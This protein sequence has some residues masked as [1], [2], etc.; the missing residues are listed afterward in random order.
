MSQ[1]SF[2][3]K[4]LSRINCPC[5]FDQIYILQLTEFAETSLA[6]K[7]HVNRSNMKLNSPVV[8]HVL[9]ISMSCDSTVPK[10]VVFVIQVSEL[11]SISQSKLLEI[12][13]KPNFYLLRSD[14][15]CQII[16]EDKGGSR[17]NNSA[18]R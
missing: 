3:R 7:D 9:I 12:S 10:H 15:N 4:F 1:V 8:D 17:L 11:K 6:W 18:I 13:T 2:L 16:S 5:I 14:V